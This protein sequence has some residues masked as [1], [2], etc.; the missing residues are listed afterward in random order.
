MIGQASHALIHHHYPHGGEYP[1][2]QC[3]MFA[4]YQQG[5]A[6]RTDKECLWR[7]DGTALPVE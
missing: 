6:S 2:E 1:V 7:K 5:K 3:P 4:A